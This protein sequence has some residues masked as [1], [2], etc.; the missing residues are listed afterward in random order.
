MDSC[1]DAA[2]CIDP[3]EAAGLNP[4]VMNPEV[5]REYLLGLQDRLCAL[6]EE[7]DGQA[8]YQTD[9]WTRAEGG[10]VRTRTD[11]VARSA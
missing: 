3:A 4:L 5:V 10:G 7:V 9:A 11:S 6:M 8:R 1:P 2:P